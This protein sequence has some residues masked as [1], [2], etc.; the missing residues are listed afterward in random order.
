MPVPYVIILSG[1][2]SIVLDESKGN[3]LE[4]RTQYLTNIKVLPRNEWEV[5]T[6][7]TASIVVGLIRLIKSLKYVKHNSCLCIGTC[8]DVRVCHNHSAHLTS[9]ICLLDISRQSLCPTIRGHDYARN[10]LTSYSSLGIHPFW[11]FRHLNYSVIQ[12]HERKYHFYIKMMVTG[13]SQNP[14]KSKVQ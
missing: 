5:K 6:L 2:Y 12:L 11:L 9:M 13:K 10:L 4:D 8:F 1:V 14:S 7:R 3:Y